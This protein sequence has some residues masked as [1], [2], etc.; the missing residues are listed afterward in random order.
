MS[1]RRQILKLK[2]AAMLGLNASF[3]VDCYT[4]PLLSMRLAT[5]NSVLR[6]R[7]SLAAVSTKFSMYLSFSVKSDSKAF[8]N[9]FFI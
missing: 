9:R 5:S 7:A 3:D 2:L 8:R 4:P 1:P 6:S